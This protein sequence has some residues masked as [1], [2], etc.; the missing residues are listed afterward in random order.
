[1]LALSLTL[2]AGT[3]GQVSLGHAALLA[4]GAYTSA[5]LS[6]DLGVPVGLAISAGGLMTAALGTLLI[7]PSFRLRGHYVSIATLAIG[8]IVSL[9]ILNWES[10][11]ARPDRRLRH[12]AAVA[13]RLSSSISATV[14]LLVQ[15]RGHGRAGAAAVAAARLA[16]RPRAAR[17]C[18]TTTSPRAP[19]A[20]ASTAT[21]RWPSP[22]AASPPA[23]AAASP[24]TLFLHQ[25]R[26]LQHAALH[27]GADHRDPGRHGQ[28][29]RRDRR[30]GRCWS[31]CPRCSASPPSTAC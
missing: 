16:S 20:S 11:D 1:M 30:L 4:I 5:L 25:P 12:P 6:L 21:R 27:P 18:A 8:E 13:V 28:R 2:V 15:L 22:S 17:R 14:D 10:R 3:V 24:R 26:D 7:S 19:M 29:H 23:S 31:A 9:V